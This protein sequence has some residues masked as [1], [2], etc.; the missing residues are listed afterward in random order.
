MHSAP[1]EASK[2]SN[3]SRK[4]LK[5]VRKNPIKVRRNQ[6]VLS[7]VLRWSEKRLQ[8]NVLSELLGE[9]QV[10]VLPVKKM[11]RRKTTKI[12]GLILFLCYKYYFVFSRK[13]RL[14][15]PGSASSES[16]TPT[17]R[18]SRKSTSNVKVSATK[19]P[20]K[21]KPAEKMLS[22]RPQRTQ[23]K[24]PRVWKFIHSKKCGYTEQPWSPEISRHVWFLGRV[25]AKIQL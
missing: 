15:S 4:R 21:S 1:N 18:S 8:I 20:T 12:W 16:S 10:Q 3:D 6:S 13:R 2:W 24:K 23:R 11:M 19:S 25:T 9:V 14:Q 17:R 5:R 7:K 22:S